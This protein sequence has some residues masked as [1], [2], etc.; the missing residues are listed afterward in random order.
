MCDVSQAIILTKLDLKIVNFTKI[1]AKISKCWGYGIQ[2][3]EMALKPILRFCSRS[4]SGLQYIFRSEII[5]Y[6][7]FQMGEK[8]MPNCIQ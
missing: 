5:T 7:F 1:N 4:W 8:V 3:F 2:T 6:L